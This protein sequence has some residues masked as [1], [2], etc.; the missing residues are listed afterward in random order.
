M[1]A[2]TIRAP[3]PHRALVAAGAAAALVGIAALRYGAGAL[4]LPLA[5]AGAVAL[6]QRPRLAVALV[7]SL[8]VICEGRSEDLMGFANFVYDPVMSG[9]TPMEGLL[10]LA[11]L[12][13][14]VGR[15]GGERPLRLPGPLTVP[16]LL[17]VMA[18][19]AGVATGAFAGVG[20]EDLLYASRQLVW[21][22]I[23]PWLVVNVVET[24]R[25]ARG[26]LALGMG[27][28]LLKAALGLGGVLAGVGMVVDGATITY[29][30]PTGNGLVLLGMLGVAAALVMRARLPLWV[31]AGSPLLVLSLA[32]SFR[33]SFWI[34]A[35]LGIVLVLLLGSRPLGR[36]LVFS[37]AAL[38]A[39]AIWVLSFQ[40]FQGQAPIVERARSL[41][42]AQV[43]RN[44]Q[45]RYR[46]EELENVT[47][48]IRGSPIT[49]LGLGVDWTA[50]HPLGVN[51]EGGRQY[52]H[53]VALWWWLKL[54]ILGPLAY[55]AVMATCLAMSWQVWR[56]SPARWLSAS[57]LA[58]LCG[59]ISIASVE[60]VGS[61]TGVD[62]RFTALI[63]AVGGLLVVLRR[64]ALRQP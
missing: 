45:D 24:E 11:V 30:D 57:G 62:P 35:A 23:V 4:I 9:P 29:Y 64:L 19:A 53:V 41:E 20:G 21:L 34:A 40:P 59:L 14:L 6:L 50:T 12:A 58:L 8:M 18:A 5:A 3:G 25:Q 36:R 52:T 42:P 46:L 61:F 56:R 22:V 32:L 38:L 17:V 44:A 63:A 13:V 48:E 28:A 16:L 55:L 15:L 7:V 43:E 10:I 26:A 1:S 27:L 60:T 2:L 39:I 47:A 54:G 51:H 49:G 31:L 37:A 33:R